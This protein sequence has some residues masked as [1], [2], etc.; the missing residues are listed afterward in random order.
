MPRLCGGRERRCIP[1]ARVTVMCSPTE[2]EAAQ[3]DN[4]IEQS[5]HPSVLRKEIQTIMKGSSFVLVNFTYVGRPS[6]GGHKTR[7]PPLPAHDTGVAAPW[8]STHGC[9]LALPPPSPAR[10]D[11]TVAHGRCMFIL[12]GRSVRKRPCGMEYQLHVHIGRTHVE[13]ANVRRG[14]GAPKSLH[15][16]PRSVRLDAARKRQPTRPRYGSGRDCPSPTNLRS[17]AICSAVGGFARQYSWFRFLLAAISATAAA[18]GG[19]LAPP[20]CSPNW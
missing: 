13:K 17:S 3:L 7:T 9:A 2:L 5:Q 10:G 6:G 8:Y 19:L 16:G 1:R 4:S 15:G 20:L 12:A 11:G 14:S 18:F